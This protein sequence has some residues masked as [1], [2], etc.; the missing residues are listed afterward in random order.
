MDATRRLARGA[1]AVGYGPAAPSG[2]ALFLLATAAGAA[3]A[4]LATVPGDPPVA[5]RDTPEVVAARPGPEL[6]PAHLGRSTPHRLMISTLDLDTG[7]VPLPDPAGATPRLPASPSRAGWYEEGRSP[8]EPGSAVLVGAAGDPPGS[9]P[10][11]FTD[12]HRLRA[13][14]R[15]QVV[16]AD[17]WTVSFQVRTV[18][19]ATDPAVRAGAGSSSSRP[20]L[21]L[22]AARPGRPGVEPVL[23]VTAA[24]VGKSRAGLPGEPSPARAADRTSGEGR[25]VYHR[26]IT[27]HGPAGR[28]N[29]RPG[30]N[31]GRPAGRVRT[32]NGGPVPEGGPAGA[33]PSGDEVR[34]E[35][36]ALEFWG[37]NRQQ[38]AE[39]LQNL[40]ARLAAV[41]RQLETVAQLRVELRE[42]R[43]EVERLREQ[44]AHPPEWPGRLV[45]LMEEAE[46]LREQAEQDARAIR[47]GRDGSS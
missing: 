25:S 10:A 20:G 15:I 16:R 29:P 7:I 19:A 22:V 4:V 33:S 9:G 41:T 42:A 11:A 30:R 24:L 21:R 31:G 28:W 32:P 40:T 43:Q 1:A 5:D 36:F 3:V 45:S 23:V 39:A 2:R 44:V 26:G 38:V 47:A 6:R 14:D 27:R 17:G 8:G 37:Y 18:A 35:D 12:L 34:L 46:R 13:G